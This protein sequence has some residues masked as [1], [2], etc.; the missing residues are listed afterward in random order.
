MKNDGMNVSVF[1]PSFFCS[2]Y[3]HKYKSA[4]KKQIEMSKTKKLSR[5]Y[6]FMNNINKIMGN[7]AGIK[8][9]EHKLIN[10]QYS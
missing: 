9:H 5:N 4:S 3:S 6:N 7:S 1:M 10:P 2:H 8:E